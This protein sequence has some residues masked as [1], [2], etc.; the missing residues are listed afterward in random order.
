MAK[1]IR[2]RLAKFIKPCFRAKVSPGQRRGFTLI[3][4]LV[5]IAI[6]AILAAMLLPALSRA[7][8]MARRTS[9]TNN[10]KQIGLGLFLY[11]QDYDGYLFPRAGASTGQPDYR[12][13][14]NSFGNGWLVTYIYGQYLPAGVFSDPSKPVTAAAMAAMKKWQNGQGAGTQFYISYG[15]WNGNANYSPGIYRDGDPTNGEYPMRVGRGNDSSIIIVSDL[16]QEVGGV[17]RI[18]HVNHTTSDPQGANQLYLD[19]HVEWKKTSELTL[20]NG[21]FNWYW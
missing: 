8:E 6:I 9:C 7:R 5:V 2:K 19:G 1:K 11:A 21:N 20:A 18:G 15:Y 12:G 17:P 3:E 16:F 14:S 4:L 10:L 13:A